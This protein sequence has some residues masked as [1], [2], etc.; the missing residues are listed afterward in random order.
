MVRDGLIL[1][2][3]TALVLPACDTSSPTDFETTVDE[4]AFEE[5]AVS[6]LQE[7]ENQGVPLPSLDR[8]LRETFQA[9]RADPSAHAEGIAFLKR[10]HA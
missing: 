7:N 10:A 6:A 8:L 5:L 3:S 4:A 1:A 9:V 2:L